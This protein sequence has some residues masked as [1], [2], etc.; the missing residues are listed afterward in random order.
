MKIYWFEHFCMRFSVLIE[1]FCRF[2]VLDDFFPMVFSVSN[3]PQCPLLQGIVVKY[4]A[5]I[6]SPTDC[7]QVGPRSHSPTSGARL[8]VPSQAPINEEF[9]DNETDCLLILHVR[10]KI[11]L[12]SRSQKMYV[13]Y[14]LNTFYVE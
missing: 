8:T 3:R 10:T 5:A 13:K 1:R 2:A 6:F 9:F 4:S 7:T 14:L 11:P 12:L